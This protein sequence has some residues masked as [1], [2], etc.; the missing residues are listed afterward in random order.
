MEKSI[1]TMRRRSNADTDLARSSLQV[2]ESRAVNR[3]FDK[4]KSHTPQFYPSI[5][6]SLNSPRNIVKRSCS[7]DIYGMI[8]NLHFYLYFGVSRAQHSPCGMVKR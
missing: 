2:C 8:V 3:M 5:V 1:S 7:T 6:S 4:A